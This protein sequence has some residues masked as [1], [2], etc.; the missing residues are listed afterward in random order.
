M[1]WRYTYY[2]D[3]SSIDIATRGADQFVH[4][5][6][7]AHDSKDR[8]DLLPKFYR[9]SSSLVWNGNPVQGVEGVHKLLQDMPRSKHEVQSFDCHPIPGVSCL[10]LSAFV[11]YS[12]I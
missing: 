6:Y 2:T 12:C 3:E 8:L 1:G 7:E 5:Y 4:L 9:E 10:I 11:V